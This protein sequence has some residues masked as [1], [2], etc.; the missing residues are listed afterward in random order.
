[1]GD[2]I[3]LF[4][5]DFLVGVDNLDEEERVYKLG[6]LKEGFYDDFMVNIELPQRFDETRFLSI[7]EYLEAMVNLGNHF[8]CFNSNFRTSF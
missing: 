7:E 6:K 1:M 3:N 8:F 2:L 5:L 4:I